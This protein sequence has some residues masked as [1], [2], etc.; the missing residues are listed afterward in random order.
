[1][2][3]IVNLFGQAGETIYKVEPSTQ[4]R[5]PPTP[6][7]S[8]GQT[9]NVNQTPSTQDRISVARQLPAGWHLHIPLEQ[10]KLEEAI[11]GVEKIRPLIQNI[12]LFLIQ[13]GDTYRISA[14]PIQPNQLQSTLR[15]I[16]QAGYRSA[17]LR[18][19]PAT[20]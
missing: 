6:P 17:I 3:L 12:S 13:I 11:E 4:T 20:P 10:K 5:Y 2:I 19:F 15:K 18:H 7:P 8:M 14:G 16:R 1:M 9:Q